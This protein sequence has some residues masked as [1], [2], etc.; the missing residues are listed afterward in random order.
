MR[1][2]AM[3]RSPPRGGLLPFLVVQLV[4]LA[5]ALTLLASR[6]AL[7]TSSPSA[8]ALAGPPVSTPHVTAQLVASAER[9]APGDTLTLGLAKQ[10]IPQWHTYWRNPGDS[11]LATE[12]SWQLPAGASA[13]PILWPAPSRH[14]LGP[15]V[16]Y[17]YEG[18]VTLLSEISVPPDARPGDTLPLRAGVS[19][20]V[21]SDVC[22]PEE[23][24]LEITLPV[25]ASTAG[26]AHPAIEAAR[27]RLP[28]PSPWE[29]RFEQDEAGLRLAVD[30]G[31]LPEGAAEI[32]FY[33]HEWGVVD[34]SAEQRIGQSEAGIVLELP[35]GQAVPA[36]PIS[37]V[38]VIREHTADGELQGSFELS[39]ARGTVAAVPTQ[40]SARAAAPASVSGIGL[41]LAILLALAGGLILNLMP[42][43]FPVLAMKTLALVR[44]GQASR[45]HVRRHGLAYLAGVL[46]SFAVLAAVVLALKAGGAHLGWGFQFQSPVFVLIVAW[47][48]FG[49]GLNLSGVFGFAAGRI[50]GAGQSLTTREGWSG[51]FFTGVLAAVV[52]TPCTAPFMGA[53]IGF[54][55]AQPP[56]TLVAIFLAL[57][58]GLALPFV[59]LAWWPALLQRL[60]HPG[61]WMERFKQALAFPMYGAAIWLTWVL[62]LQRGPD[63][64]LVALG[65]ML[66]LALAAWLFDASSR[67]SASRTQRLLQGAAAVLLAATL[68]VGSALLPATGSGA[69][70]QNQSG[71]S[72][73][74]PAFD[75]W[76]EARVEA[77]RGEG[78][79]VFVNFTAAWCITCLV[80]ERVALAQ[81]S[82]S[83]HFENEGIA[84]LKADWTDRNADIAAA[85]ARFGRSGV[86]LY[87]Y[88]PADPAATAVVLPQILSPDIVLRALNAAENGRS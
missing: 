52:A 28:R 45:S 1:S 55:M 21:C 65:G 40:P 2:A 38:L 33:P 13:G 77:L 4:L 23:V 59:A 35:P 69:I 12:I 80:N 67:A 76:S 82:V 29:A 30:T 70:A 17:G 20:L 5:V 48:L 73:S 58:L 83:E 32:W 56:L 50:A 31:P 36:G 15:I 79:P 16:N 47:L 44:H 42:C 60:P 61:P 87:L 25:A 71:T 22:I 37:G 88:Y 18:D 72:G 57:G 7:A 43:V 11:G 46:A 27:A 26:A 75:A 8:T 63:S 49:V 84:Y 74:G 86:P 19:W 24:T 81:P 53:A 10:I 68:L 54:A 85:L 64:V 3:F 62:A 41:P 51:S 14:A 34:H 66:V 6:P 39:A 9:V 78:R